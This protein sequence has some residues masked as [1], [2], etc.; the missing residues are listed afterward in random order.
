MTIMRW[1]PFRE[2]E[3]VSNRLN[4]MFNLTR[5]DAREALTSA[6]WVPAVDIVETPEEYLLKVECPEVKKDELKVSVENGVLN[7]QGE[8]KREE[9]EKDKKFHRVERYYGSFMRSFAL[10]ENVDDTKVSAD[11]KEGLLNVH[12]PKSEKSKPR[13]IDIK[14]N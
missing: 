3:D 6:D 1:D 14:V 9:E 12:V 13:A 11:F 4:R 8:R 7:I 5:G 10:P 2:L